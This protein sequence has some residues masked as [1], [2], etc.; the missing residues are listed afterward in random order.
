M[1]YRKQ[2]LHALENR[3]IVRIGTQETQDFV[4]ALDVPR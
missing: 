2:A 1:K 3:R 4:Q